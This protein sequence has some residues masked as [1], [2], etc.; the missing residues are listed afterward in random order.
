MGTCDAFEY[1]GIFDL[2]GRT[3]RTILLETSTRPYPIYET[4]ELY[5]DDTDSSYKGILVWNAQKY[6]SGLKRTRE[7]GDYTPDVGFYVIPE[8]GDVSIIPNI[9]FKQVVLVSFD[10][11]SDPDVDP[12]GSKIIKF[13]SWFLN[14]VSDEINKDELVLATGGQQLYVHTSSI[15]KPIYNDGL[16]LYVRRSVTYFVRYCRMGP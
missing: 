7:D 6:Y 3:F 8:F 15:S 14:A 13:I 1:E 5:D 2:L 16:S 4:R 12:F 10:S 11:N 9:E